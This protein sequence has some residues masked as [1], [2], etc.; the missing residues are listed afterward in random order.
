MDETGG[1]YVTREQLE[2]FG[3]G[4]A[5]KG[6][7]ELRLA[8][9]AE[10]EGPVFNGPTERPMR[11]RIALPQDEPALLELYLQDI[12]E[13]AAH[14]APVDVDKCLANIQVGTRRR[15]GVVGVVDGPEGKPVGM[16]ILHP[17]Q[18][19]W[20]QGWYFFEVML[21][22]AKE[23]RKLTHTD[24]LMAFARWFVDANSAK[25]GHAMYLICGVLG[26]WRVRAKVALYRRKFKQAG[27]VFCYPAPPEMGS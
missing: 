5:Q 15:G 26:G 10:R 9:N 21:Y 1:L 8:L 14:I 2:R 18:W 19:H 17:C 24:D 22:V 4:D 27:A 20:S 25:I 11:V 23:H 3:G 7:R 13:N 16:V 12:R 6:R